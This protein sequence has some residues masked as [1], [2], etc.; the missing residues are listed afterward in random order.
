MSTRMFY[1]RPAARFLKGRTGCTGGDPHLHYSVQRT[2]NT[3]RH[4][5]YNYRPGTEAAPIPFGNNGRAAI[6]PF[7]WRAPQQ[8]DPQGW[9]YYNKKVYLRTT[10]GST[11][12]GGGAMSIRLWKK[13]QAHPRPC[14][15]S[16]RRWKHADFPVAFPNPERNCG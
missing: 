4:W 5:H 8:V 3:A 10:D 7:G 1:R 9:R 12:T 2:T 13:G 6:D 16:N 14:D 15:E 11:L